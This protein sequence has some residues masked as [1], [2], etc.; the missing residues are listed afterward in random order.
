MPS[1]RC[2]SCWQSRRSSPSSSDQDCR[3]ATDGAFAP[4]SSSA[5]AASRA[6][7]RAVPGASW[8]AASSPSSTNGSRVKAAA[9]LI[10]SSE[11]VVGAASTATEVE[12]AIRLG[13]NDSGGSRDQLLRGSANSRAEIR[14][15]FWRE[16]LEASRI[17]APRE[18]PLKQTGRKKPTSARRGSATLC[19]VKRALPWIARRPDPDRRAR[20]GAH[21]GARRRRRDGSGRP[22]QPRCGARE[23]RRLARPAGLA[24]R[25]VRAAA[26]GR[27]AGLRAAPGRPEG[28]AGRDQQVGVLVQPLPGR[29]PRLPAAR[30]GARARRSRSSASTPATARSPRATSWRSIRSRSRPTWTRTRRSPGR[31]RRPPTTP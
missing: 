19:G 24:A 12:S 2:G 27:S 28:Q 17:G 16:S 25:A 11:G 6:R 20:R 30:D 26:R 10:A 4:A 9:R 7:R 22:V 13:G 1:A 21:A 3:Q 15:L 5:S 31:S 8:T 18:C 14:G 29:V 23:A